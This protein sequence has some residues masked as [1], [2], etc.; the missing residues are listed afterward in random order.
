MTV[1]VTRNDEVKVIALNGKIDVATSDQTRDEILGLLENKPTIILMPQ[2]DY[3][4]SSGLRTL[5]MIARKAKAQGIKIIYAAAVQEVL[6]VFDMTGFNKMLRCV[7]TLED[8]L[9]EFGVQS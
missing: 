6:D 2:V 5:L 1:T 9:K 8:A 3:V 4:S 7:P